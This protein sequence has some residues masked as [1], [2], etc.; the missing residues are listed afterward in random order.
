M[1]REATACTDLVEKIKI[2]R[3]LAHLQ[4]LGEMSDQLEMS[5][6]LC[7]EAVEIFGVDACELWRFAWE[8]A[9]VGRL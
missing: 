5:C 8:C 2:T 6:V 7:R 3:L 1:A 4:L 9:G